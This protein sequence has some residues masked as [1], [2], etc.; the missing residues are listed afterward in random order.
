M[1]AGACMAKVA[2]IV[3]SD[4]EYGALWK[5]ILP[6]SS[7]WRFHKYFVSKSPFPQQFSTI[8]ERFPDIKRTNRVNGEQLLTRPGF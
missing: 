7:Y 5:S 2:D 1:I 3:G 8:S 6:D 4:A